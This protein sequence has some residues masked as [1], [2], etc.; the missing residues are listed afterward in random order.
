MDY[1]AAQ[2]KRPLKMNLSSLMTASTPE[3]AKQAREFVNTTDSV[4]PETAAIWFYMQNHA[5]AILARKRMKFEPLPAEEL[6]L[7]NKYHRTMTREAL[8]M[9]YY[10]LL[11][12]TRES[13][14]INNLD[15][16]PIPSARYKEF[17]A[18]I[19]PKGSSGAVESFYSNAPAMNLGRY[20]AHMLT[21]F[22]QGHWSS[23]FGG[24]AWA[25]VAKVLDDFVQGE[26]TAEM[27]LDTAYTLA[28]NNGPIFNKGLVFK[29]YDPYEIM[30]ILDVQRSGQI[31]QFVQTEH[32]SKITA[33]QREYRMCGYHILGEEF[34]GH[35]DWFK[36]EALGAVGSY[37]AEKAEQQAKYGIP[38][39]AKQVIAATEAKQQ[40]EAEEYYTMISPAGTSLKFKKLK[41]EEL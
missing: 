17:V 7:V 10:L 12:C 18:S 33:V 37:D 4:E 25:N 36:V 31:P 34:G 21:L 40:K 1:L 6:G 3:I 8:R 19:R 27:M 16:V 32:S 39:T 11:I 22:E 29:M 14:H 28:H 35:V 30:R 9:F 41:R 20:T 24:K 15:D 13:R 5:Q 38:D 26:I 2:D 23:S